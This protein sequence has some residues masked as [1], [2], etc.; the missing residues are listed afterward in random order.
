MGQSPVLRAVC[1]LHVHVLEFREGILHKGFCDAL[2]E[3]KVSG[4]NTKE[5]LWYFQADLSAKSAHQLSMP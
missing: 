3:I 5:I 4:I 1:Q 2:H